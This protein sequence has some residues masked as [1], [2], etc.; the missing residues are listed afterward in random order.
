MDQAPEAAEVVAINLIPMRPGV[1]PQRF[2]E[3]SAAVDQPTCLSKEV[4]LGFDAYRLSEQDAR[5]LGA[6]IL[7]VMRVRSW[8]EWEQV[9]DHDPE[10]EPVTRGFEALVDPATVRTFFVTPARLMNNPT[11]QHLTSSTTD[12]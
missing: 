10:L 7:E 1:D 12:E 2:A 3:F 5:T 8:S 11:E 9:R 6:D 4:V